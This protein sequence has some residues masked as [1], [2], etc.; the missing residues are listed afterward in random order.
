MIPPVRPYRDLIPILL[1]AAAGATLAGLLA[2]LVVAVR[3]WLL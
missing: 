2:L 3:Y 1:L